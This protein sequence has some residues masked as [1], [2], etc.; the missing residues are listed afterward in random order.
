[1]PLTA[2]AQRH[3]DASVPIVSAPDEDRMEIRIPKGSSGP[4][5]LDLANVYGRDAER[6]ALAELVSAATVRLHLLTGPAGSGKTTLAQALAMD[7]ST[8]LPVHWVAGH[9]RSSYLD[10]MLAVGVDLDADTVPLY[11]AREQDD[12]ALAWGT[13]L[14]A[15]Q[16]AT[17]RLLVIDNA[18]D[19]LLRELLDMTATLAGTPWLVLV[20]T[21]VGGERPLPDGATAQT[22]AV[23]AADDAV[24][25]LLKR[26]GGYGEPTPDRR[27]AALA[28]VEL[29]GR[30]PLAIH[31]AGSH[32]GSNLVRHTLETYVADLRRLTPVAAPADDPIGSLVS[33]LAL[34]LG[35]LAPTGDAARVARDL[36]S[37]VT[38]LDFAR[39]VPVQT[40]EP[41]RLS[42][43]GALAQAP[44]WAVPAALTSLTQLRLLERLPHLDG[45]VFTVHPLIIEAVRGWA[46]MRSARPRALTIAAHVL[47]QA[48]AALPCAEPERW[49][50]WQLTVP[51]VRM[52]LEALDESVGAGAV[53]AAVRTAGR[54]AGYLAAIGLYRDA[55]R[56]TSRAVAA[57]T[58][59]RRD[60]PDRLTARY[61]RA[62]VLE[63]SG[64]FHEAEWDLETAARQQFRQLGAADPRSLA[65][66]HHLA[67]VWHQLG[68]LGPAERLFRVVLAGRRLLL[69]RADDDPCRRVAVVDLAAT[70]QGLAAV[71]HAAGRPR[72]ALSLLR[73]AHKVRS[74]HLGPEHADT[75]ITEHSLAYA[76]QAIGGAENLAKAK[77]EF[78]RIFET[79][80]RRFGANHPNTLITRHNLAWIKQ[81]RGQYSVAKAEFEAI[82]AVQRRR[83]GEDHRHTV[84]TKANLAWVLLKQEDYTAARKLFDEVLDIRLEQF[85]PQHPD[86]QTT[87]GNLGWLTLE[88]GD[89]REAEAILRRLYQDRVRC[90]G[91]RHPRTLTTQ[92]NLA[93]SLRQQDTDAGKLAQAEELFCQVLDDQI[94]TIGDEHASTVATM[95]NYALTLKARGKLIEAEENL[96]KVVRIQRNAA[97]YGLAEPGLAT[98]T[99]NL[100]LV[101]RAAGDTTRANDLERGLREDQQHAAQGSSALLPDASD[102][103]VD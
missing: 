8:A 65:T 32:L 56:M 70:Q 63:A 23:P 49:R 40:L 80:C 25:M 69:A 43:V 33:V 46:E 74:V 72:Q 10:G 73:Q 78:Q 1:M 4:P 54:V 44:P 60:D 89:F 76:L 14:A 94:A 85:G 36:L 17:P 39:P 35:A 97:E 77:A 58:R 30:L 20:T 51:H 38:V 87:R 41:G 103:T 66:C 96:E 84:S 83:L 13:V 88:E 37:L 64:R 15:A 98:T 28:T 19:R 3:L 21:R 50:E 9:S 100:I 6:A 57:S 82:L 99:N 48:T 7:L 59:L 93:L 75:L 2:P 52:L 16:P 53:R 22:V 61:Q 68:R 29:L 79:R 55:L 18:D 62:A 5:W 67:K 91:R 12:T 71:M 90:L 24:E 102:G 86:T 27:A 26:I 47:D 95:N 11:R 81:D 42:M 92:H 34:S 31:L 45:D 101:L